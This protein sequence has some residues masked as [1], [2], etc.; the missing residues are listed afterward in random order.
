MRLFC[1]PCSWK[2]LAKITEFSGAPVRGGFPP[3]NG[4]PPSV[5][6]GSQ[7]RYYDPPLLFC[8]L[9]SYYAPQIDR[10]PLSKTA[11][12]SDKLLCFFRK[13]ASFDN[14]PFLYQ[15]RRQAQPPQEIAR[16]F[17]CRDNSAFSVSRCAEISRA[18]ATLDTF[19][20]LPLD[21][22]NISCYN[23]YTALEDCGRGL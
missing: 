2:A 20:L 15:P 16:Y 1:S 18:S 13:V 7:G 11:V 14:S 4:A 8:V 22:S 9:C 10:C 6:F 17:R 3:W 23:A 19:F 5:A 21:N 12:L